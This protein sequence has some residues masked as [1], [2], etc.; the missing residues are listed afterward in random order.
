MGCRSDRSPVRGVVVTA[1]G[2]KGAQV[3]LR[4][5]LELFGIASRKV[6]SMLAVP[7]SH[8]YLLHL[9]VGSLLTDRQSQALL[10]L[11]IFVAVVKSQAARAEFPVGE[12]DTWKVICP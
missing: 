11:R 2:W 3:Q 1:G 7:M 10:T 9:A 5:T 8:V 4:E 12:Y 6:E